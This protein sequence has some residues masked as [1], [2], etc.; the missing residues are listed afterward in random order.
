MNL[1]IDSLVHTYADFG[2]LAWTKAA[3]TCHQ[4]VTCHADWAATSRAVG[5]FTFIAQSNQLH[6]TGTLIADTDPTSVIPYF[7]TANH[8]VSVQDGSMGAS[9][10]EF[11]WLYQ[12]PGCDQPAPASSGGGDQSPHTSRDSSLMNPH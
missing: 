11:Y 12:T 10:M 2:L 6:C 4:D 8:C 7:L 3:D 9:S 1:V 5:G